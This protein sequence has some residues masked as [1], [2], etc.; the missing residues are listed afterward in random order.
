MEFTREHNDLI[1]GALDIFLEKDSPAIVARDSEVISFSTVLGSSG[2]IEVDSNGDWDI[3]LDGNKYYKIEKEVYS[4]IDY[5]K[6]APPVE[7][8]L[9][10][11]SALYKKKLQDRSKILIEMII[12]GLAKLIMDDKISVDVDVQFGHTLIAKT[13]NIGNVKIVL[14]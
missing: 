5:S 6:K 12:R 9:E 1:Y 13:N 7:D 8:L 14:N 4:V 2:S 3:I 11:L 10:T